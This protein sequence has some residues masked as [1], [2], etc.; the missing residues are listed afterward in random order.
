MNANYLFKYYPIRFWSELPTAKQKQL[1]EISKF[2]W[3]KPTSN[4]TS[5]ESGLIG[6]DI[7]WAI[8]FKSLESM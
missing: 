4:P 7:L 2:I 3:E 6:S 8:K 5:W 1:G